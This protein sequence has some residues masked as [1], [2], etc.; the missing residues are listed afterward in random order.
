MPRVSGTQTCFDGSN[1]ASVSPIEANFRA[2][3]VFPVTISHQYFLG[4][5][6]MTASVKDFP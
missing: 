5:V 1:R 6:S 4:K 2:L 3:T